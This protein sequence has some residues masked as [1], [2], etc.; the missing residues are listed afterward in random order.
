MCTEYLKIFAQPATTLIVA[1]LAYW[2]GYRNWLRQKKKEIYY[3]VEQER[4]KNR[5]AACKAAWTL[6]EYISQKENPKTMIVKRGSKDASYYVLRRAQGE[7]YLRV[8][9]TVFYGQGHGICL[10]EEVRDLLYEARTRVYRL[11]EAETRRGN[12]TAEE[13]RIEKNEIPAR[14]DQ[15]REELRKTLK[16]ELRNESVERHS[17]TEHG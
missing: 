9:P 6:L 16:S 13:I 8:L 3:G 12:T 14:I 5:L 2:L 11:L 17:R 15:I 10:P 7:E 4:Y 1:L